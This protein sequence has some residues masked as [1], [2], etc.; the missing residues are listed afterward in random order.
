MMIIVLQLSN[1]TDPFILGS[2]F[3]LVASYNTLGA[4]LEYPEVKK[5]G[6]RVWFYAVSTLGFAMTFLTSFLYYYAAIS[7]WL[8]VG[9]CA[10]SPAL[11]SRAPAAP[12]ETG[13]EEGVLQHQDVHQPAVDSKLHHCTEV[14]L[15]VEQEQAGLL[16]Q[17]G[18]NQDADEQSPLH[19]HTPSAAP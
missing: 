6:V 15:A 10:V 16:M 2:S 9:G 7:P 11:I 5:W 8:D 19:V 12:A 18:S 4:A 3:L 14:M 1:V 13:E 17:D